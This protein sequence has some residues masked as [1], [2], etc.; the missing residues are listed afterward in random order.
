MAA[1]VA[2]SQLPQFAASTAVRGRREWY[3]MLVA[4]L[5]AVGRQAAR[6]EAFRLQ[7]LNATANDLVGHAI[8]W[9]DRQRD[10]PRAPP[11][12]RENLKWGHEFCLAFNLKEALGHKNQIHRLDLIVERNG[13]SY[14]ATVRLTALHLKSPN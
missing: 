14:E 12:N 5:T 8:D 2:R 9:A 6:D 1:S 10:D 11:E 3:F 13:P 4:F 7:P